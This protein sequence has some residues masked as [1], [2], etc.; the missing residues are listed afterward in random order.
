M[1]PHMIDVSNSGA[2]FGALSKGGLWG[3]LFLD[4]VVVKKNSSLVKI[5][6]G[7]GLRDD[8]KG[9]RIGMWKTWSM[10]VNEYQWMGGQS[11]TTA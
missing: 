10:N 2:H 1:A 4:P 7:G 9:K 3:G 11:L 6:V 5:W 8:V